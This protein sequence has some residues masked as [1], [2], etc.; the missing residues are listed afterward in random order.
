M[1]SST[2][3]AFTGGERREIN[4]QCSLLICHEFPMHLKPSEC[5][6]R[7]PHHGRGKTETLIKVDQDGYIYTSDQ[8]ESTKAKGLA[9]QG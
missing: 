6:Y 7:P 9:G 2:V 4:L 1:L 3:A 8:S 5:I